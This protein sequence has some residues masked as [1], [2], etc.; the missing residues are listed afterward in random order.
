M[1]YEAAIQIL[2]V[3]MFIHT[4]VLICMCNDHTRLYGKSR[5]RI[6]SSEQTQ[7]TKMS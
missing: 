6:E 1:V 7:I 3:T 2:Q 4:S 5:D